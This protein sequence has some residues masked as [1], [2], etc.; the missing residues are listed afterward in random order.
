MALQEPRDAAPGQHGN[1]P[2]ATGSNTPGATAAPQ[3]PPAPHWAMLPIILIGTFVIT[4]DVFIV[5]V[6]IP[7]T[8]RDLHAGSS[9]VEFIVAGYA[10]AYAAGLITGGRLGDLYGRRRMFL[11]GVALFTLSSAWAGSAPT[12]GLAEPTRASAL[13]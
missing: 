12:A 8:Q 3:E 10:L 6:A 7:A 2:G 4:L 9:A 5:N 13:L 1:Q 11:I